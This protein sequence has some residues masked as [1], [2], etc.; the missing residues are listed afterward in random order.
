MLGRML[1]LFLALDQLLDIWALA[2][3][4][5][6][7]TAVLYDS[8]VQQDADQEGNTDIKL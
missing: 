6:E 3:V 8:P 5:I 7:G 4:Y 1:L 2:G